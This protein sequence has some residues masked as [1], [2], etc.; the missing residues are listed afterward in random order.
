ML[1]LF[2]A[3]PF[4]PATAVGWKTAARPGAIG[5]LAVALVLLVGLFLADRGS[6]SQFAAQ[7]GSLDLRWAGVGLV[8]MAT[9]DFAKAWRWQVL[10]GQLQPSYRRVLQ[11]QVV[12][13]AANT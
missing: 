1:D 7:F 13:Q 6:L 9:V 5:W 3:G 2:M 12:G 8:L 11:A 10:Y 4:R